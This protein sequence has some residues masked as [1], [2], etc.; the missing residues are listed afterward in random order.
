MMNTRGQLKFAKALKERDPAC[1]EMVYSLQDVE[2]EPYALCRFLRAT[3]FNADVM[4]QRLESNKDKWEAVKKD[5]F[6]PGRYSGGV[7]L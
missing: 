6:Y 1:A 3:K 7:S 5:Q 4:L 2:D